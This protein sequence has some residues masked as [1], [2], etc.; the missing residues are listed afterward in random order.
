MVVT[1]DGSA[2]Q[3]P[4]GDPD[5]QYIDLRDLPVPDQIHG[6]EVFAGTIPLQYGGVETGKTCGLLA[7]WTR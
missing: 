7:I 2:V 5:R 6:V 1:V 4:T 3:V